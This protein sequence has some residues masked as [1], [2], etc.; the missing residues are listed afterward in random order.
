VLA[1]SGQLAKSQTSTA[2]AATPTA[3]NINFTQL[4]K[5]KLKTG[6]PVLDADVIY[7]SPSSVVLEGE[8]LILGPGGLVDNQY[9]WQGVDL[10]KQQGY[11]IDSVTM[12][13]IGTENN[14][15]VYHLI[16]SHK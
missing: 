6:Y 11:T 9:L 15:D 4:F 3:A 5:A 2:V 1:I 10:V 8:K 12:S 7:Q 16:L 13:G 14:P